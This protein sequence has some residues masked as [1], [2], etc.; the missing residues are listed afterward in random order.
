MTCGPLAPSNRSKIT[1]KDLNLKMKSATET[2]IKAFVLDLL[3]SDSDIISPDFQAFS[4]CG[5]AS[6]KPSA[7]DPVL[8]CCFS[9]KSKNTTNLVKLHKSS[10]VKICAGCRHGMLGEHNNLTRDRLL[11]YFPFTKN[12]AN[13]IPRRQGGGSFMFYIYKLEDVVQAAISKFGSLYLMAK[14]KNK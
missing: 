13:D 9:C 12:E 4:P 8:K 1:K 6:F 5:S 2:E 10:E 11:A 7:S 3:A 14:A